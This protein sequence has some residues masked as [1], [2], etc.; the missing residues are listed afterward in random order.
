MII[1][2]EDFK[3]KVEETKKEYSLSNQDISDVMEIDYTYIFR[4]FK[5]NANPGKKVIDG[6]E[7]FCR[8]YNLNSKDY[9]FLE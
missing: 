6:V 8:K 2:I 1:K 3:E 7:K 9:I 4:L 5:Q